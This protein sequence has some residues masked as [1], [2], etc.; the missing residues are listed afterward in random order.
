[1]IDHIDW[2]AEALIGYQTPAKERR[3]IQKSVSN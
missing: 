3:S 2:K 1:M